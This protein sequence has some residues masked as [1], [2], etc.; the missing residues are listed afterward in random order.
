[1]ELATP[2]ASTR[3]FPPGRVVLFAAWERFDYLDTWLAE[4]PLGRRWVAAW[5]SAQAVTDMVAG[6][7]DQL[8]A[9]R[10]VEAMQERHRTDFHQEFTTLRFRCLEEHG[11]WLGRQRIVPPGPR[12]SASSG[13]GLVD[14]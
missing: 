1:M 5:R 14:G 11:S 10:H 6:R 4:D 7:S 2:L 9:R 8:G 3:R 13:P 12:S